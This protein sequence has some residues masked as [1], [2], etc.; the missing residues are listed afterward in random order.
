MLSELL[1]SG[2]MVVDHQGLQGSVDIP[3]QRLI[4]DD[5]SFGRLI[6]NECSAKFQPQQMHRYRRLKRIA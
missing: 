4:L 2:V 3:L 5:S 6:A 1:D